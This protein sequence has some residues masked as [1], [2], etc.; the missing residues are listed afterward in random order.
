MEL[1]QRRT[2]GSMKEDGL[3]RVVWLEIWNVA[4]IMLDLGPLIAETKGKRVLLGY[5][6]SQD[7]GARGGR[8]SQS[9][10]MG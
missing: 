4:F 2:D 7:R 10:G 8:E 6:S 9:W 3:S 1:N 5:G